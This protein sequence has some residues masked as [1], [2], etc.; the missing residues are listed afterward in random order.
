MDN[1]ASI[2]LGLL[3]AWCIISFTY[4]SRSNYRTRGMINPE[5]I[6]E[7]S[8]QNPALV[9]TGLATSTGPKPSVMDATPAPMARPV[10]MAQNPQ[11]P[12]QMPSP[13]PMQM[14]MPL[15]TQNNMPSRPVSITSPSA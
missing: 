14:H 7:S 12:K 8:N 1:I 2:I 3:I 5:K 9:G 11:M 10:M 15:P 13:T 6:E 4:G